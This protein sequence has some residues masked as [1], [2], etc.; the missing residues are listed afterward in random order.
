MNKYLKYCTIY[1]VFNW[2][3]LFAQSVVAPTKILENDEFTVSYSIDSIPESFNMA[4]AK[5]TGEYKLADPNQP[6]NS[7]DIVVKQLPRKRLLFYGKSDNYNFIVYEQGG[8]GKHNRI[9]LF[10]RDSIN[11]RPIWGASFIDSVSNLTTMVKLITSQ[12]VEDVKLYRKN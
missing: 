12:K 11:Y 2:V 7:T 1:I 6:Y 9:I 10:Q 3:T 8:R 5:L 4:F